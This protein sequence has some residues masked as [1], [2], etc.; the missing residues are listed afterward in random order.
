MEW[1]W[2]YLIPIIMTLLSAVCY[3]AVFLINY[4]NGKTLKEAAS[5]AAEA[6]QIFKGVNGVI[7]IARADGTIVEL[8]VEDEDK[9]TE[10]QVEEN[11]SEEA[12]LT[13]TSQVS[14]LAATLATEETASEE[15]ATE[16]TA[17][18]EQEFEEL[19]KS[20]IEAFGKLFTYFKK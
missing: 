19:C 15:K 9:V 13:A 14:T 6:V 3:I 11:T 8:P 1:N 5:E 12:T 7:R 16:E 17:T 18:S 20:V 2:Y 10:V 4:K